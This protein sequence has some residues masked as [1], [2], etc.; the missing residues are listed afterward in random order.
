VKQREKVILIA[1]LVA[2]IYAAYVLFFSAAPLLTVG[3]P[4]KQL[5]DVRAFALDISTR[6]AKGDTSSTDIYIVTRAAT[7]W[8]KK[9]FLISE[10]PIDTGRP[11]AEADVPGQTV[12]FTYTGYLKVGDKILAVISGME[13]EIGETLDSGGYRIRDISMAH[14][15]IEKSDDKTI[16]M[17]AMEET[18][19]PPLKGESEPAIAE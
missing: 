9:P 16:L 2:M 15:I 12:P 4:E 6:L 14:V 19:M 8:D 11:T 5:K 1:A 18:S 10:H 3:N 17:L 13:Y 7:E